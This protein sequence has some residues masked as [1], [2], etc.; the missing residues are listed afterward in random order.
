MKKILSLVAVALLFSASAFAEGGYAPPQYP[1]TIPKGGSG[2]T[3]QQGAITA[4][5]G[6]QS[7]GK[8]LRSDGTNAALGNIQ[9]GDVPTLNQNTTGTAASVTA[10]TQSA[11]TSAPNLA[12]VGTLGSVTVS[13]AATAAR[14]SASG[15]DANV[16]PV[17]TTGQRTTVTEGA[18]RD[19]TTLHMIES[20][21]NGGWQQV[22][23]AVNGLVN[24]KSQVT[25]ILPVSNGGFGKNT[26]VFDQL[27]PVI[28]QRGSVTPTITFS[29]STMASPTT[30]ISN[31]GGVPD[32]KHFSFSALS[33]VQRST[34]YPQYNSLEDK[35]IA[36]EN[37]PFWTTFYISAPQ[38]D[39]IRYGDG[40]G[41][42]IWIDDI[43]VGAFRPYAQTGTAQAGSTTSI[44]LASGASATN[45]QYNQQTA[46]I[47]SGTG[48]G[49]NCLISAYVGSTKVATCSNTLATAPDSTSVYHVV[50]DKNG[51]YINGL[52]GSVYYLNFNFGSRQTHKISIYSGS[53]YGI[54]I[55]AYDTVWPASRE[56]ALP[57]VEIGDSFIEGSGGPYSNNANEEIMLA[58]NLGFKNYTDGE[59]SSGWCMPYITLGRLN[60]QD[61]IAPPTESWYYTL[62]GASAGTYTISVTYN[63][64]T[65]TTG[66]LAYNANASSVQTAVQA[67]SN[68]TASSV[69]VGGG[70][71]TNQPFFML[72]HNMP[73]ATLTVNTGGLT[74]LTSLTFA[75]WTGMVA[76]RVPKDGQGNALPFI[77]YV[78]GSGN[79][80]VGGFTP[81]QI[82]ACATY[83]AQQIVARFP[84]AIT[85]FSGVVAATGTTIGS[86]D[87]STNAAIQTAAGYLPSI[88]GNVPF[89]DTFAAGSGANYWIA[90]SG[91]VASPTSAYNDIMRS[92]TAAGHPTGDGHAYIAARMATLFKQLF[93][94]N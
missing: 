60:F 68:V 87:I 22:V 34:A 1:I 47:D 12:T 21:L 13:G 67:L 36:P 27:K 2:A 92:I 50:D 65:Q 4:L 41:A 55:G 11:I 25:S 90:G 44:T 94:S 30:I 29:S 56:S 88:N 66:T 23:S 91:T 89:I 28:A 83:G 32:T 63:S 6:T 78:Q 80:A 82:G 76:P 75:N 48:V 52:D 31:A 40:S 35:G 54:N 26:G 85:I 93:G 69:S 16:L 86:T 43:Y 39:Y 19:N 38:F 53:F 9:A 49:Q 71:T 84:T 37:S 8:Y 5:T 73:G 81:S 58:Q 7:A 42:Y 3:T 57:M 74:G 51:Y 10:A 79:D 77:L 15:T 20:Y 62:N 46:H 61:R 70:Q 72:L 24:L 18:L 17:G 59:G 14:F 64:S 45:G 33:L